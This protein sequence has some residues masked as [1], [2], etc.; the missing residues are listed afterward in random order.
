MGAINYFTSD[1]ITLGIIPYDTDDFT[2]EDGTINYEEINCCY[3]EDEKNAQN[4][5][6]KYNVYFYHIT[7]KPGYYEGFTVNIENNFPIFYNDWQ[8]KREAQKE[9][10]RIKKLLMELAGIGLVAVS[11]GWCTGYSNYWKTLKQVDEA[12]KEMREESKSI[13]TYRILER[14]EAC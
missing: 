5:I 11:A 7:I 13:P 10:T 2:M 12:I 4:I 9:I 1:Y 3:E 14:I 8:E 6:D